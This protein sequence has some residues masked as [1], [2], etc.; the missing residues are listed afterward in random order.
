MVTVR[1]PVLA[2]LVSILIGCGGGSGGGSF[3]SPPISVALSMSTVVVSADGA[4]TYV[5]ITI[6]ST[7][8]TALV[9]F[10]GMPDGVQAT[11]QSTDTNPSGLLTFMATGKVS[12]G[13]YVPI[14][15]VNSAGQTAMLHFTMIVPAK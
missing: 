12:A 7:S 11:Y 2:L 8:E 3:V 5:Q 1:K 13:T 14:I 15:T 10:V 6:G 4:P 9:S